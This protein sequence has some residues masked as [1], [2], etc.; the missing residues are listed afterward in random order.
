MPFRIDFPTVQRKAPLAGVYRLNVDLE[1]STSKLYKF[2]SNAPF[3][4]GAGWSGSFAL[5]PRSLALKSQCLVVNE[6][7]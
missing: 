6:P 5:R 2:L 3:L 7:L 4:L 1:F